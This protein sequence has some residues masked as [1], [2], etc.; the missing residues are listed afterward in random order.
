MIHFDKVFFQI[1]SFQDKFRNNYNSFGSSNQHNVDFISKLQVIFIFR[2]D[3][4]Q[5]IEI[6]HEFVINNETMSVKNETQG[7]I[8]KVVFYQTLYYNFYCFKFLRSNLKLDEFI[9]LTFR[10]THFY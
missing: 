5:F 6:I 8:G 1:S 7:E 3:R 4:D 2:P 9:I 10:G